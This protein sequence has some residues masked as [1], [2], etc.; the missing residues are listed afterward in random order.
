M[1]GALFFCAGS[2]LHATGTRDMERLG[3]LLS[4]MPWTGSLMIL[5]AVA[6]VPL[7]PLNGFV[8][9]WLL[10]VGLLECGLNSSAD[11]GLTALLSVGALALVGGLAALAYVRLC[12]VVLLGSPRSTAA[13]HAHE[14]SG[15]L[16]GPAVLLVVL[17]LSAAV[18]PGRVAGLLDPAIRAIL[19]RRPGPAA[20][21]L[22]TLGQI[23]AWTLATLCLA[24]GLFWSW[25]RR[26]P[27]SA[28]VTWGCGYARPTPRMQ[29]T[30]RSFSEMLAEHLLPRFLRPRTG[31]TAPRGLFPSSGEFHSAS[32]DPVSVRVYEPLFA[33]CAR[34]FTALRILQ[35]GK[36]NVY[37]TYVLVALLLGLAWASFRGWW[38]GPG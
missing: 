32:P 16:L 7:P 11:R 27:S 37:L 22:A 24:S 12:G 4:R 31:R 19:G 21:P 26:G 30:G 36:T 3:G 34:R 35:Q 23:N 38:G 28:A 10:Y 18:V 14:S 9:K 33:R 29:Y 13:E 8:S 20:A 17:C 1:K 6:I 5:G 15:W 25:L 2:I